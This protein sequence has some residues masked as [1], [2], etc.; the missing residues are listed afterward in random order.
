MIVTWAPGEC[1][2]VIGQPYYIEVTKDGGGIFDSV[3]INTG[4]PFAYGNA[5]QNGISIA[6][7]DLAGTIMEEES[8]GSATRPTVKITAEPAPGARGTND[9]T[10]SWNTDV[11]SDS[12]IEF[13]V[14]TPPY[15][16]STISTQLVT[17]HSLTVTGLQSHTLYHYRVTSSKPGY[18]SVVSRD[19]VICTRPAGSNLLINP[20]FE[21]GVGISPRSTLVGWTKRGSVD[22]RTA[23]G[24]WFWSLKPTNGNWLLEGAVNGSSS[25]GHVFQRVSNAIPGA[26]YTF[27]AW[28]M[29]AM[30]E[31]NNWKYDVWDRDQRLE[32]MRLGIDPTGGTNINAATIQ[33]TPRMYSHRRYTQ[34][35]RSA[36]AQSSNVTVFVHMKG[37]GGEWHTYAVDDCALTHEEIPVRFGPAILDTNRTLNVPLFSRANRSNRVESTSSLQDS[38]SWSTVTNFLNRS[39]VADF[40]YPATSN[41]PPRFFRA[42]TW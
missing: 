17:A 18:R 30:R 41:S 34:I 3:Y 15:T 9:L 33:W 39:G 37:D 32:Y 42:R 13:A 1:P 31:N 25:D 12:K 28:V 14:E 20:G 21:E 8:N 5:F 6:N 22:I 26:E 36:V 16:G 4:N 7:V 11:A 35:A 10:I 19:F 24:S 27:S 23:D 38:N 2:L 29:T 40:K